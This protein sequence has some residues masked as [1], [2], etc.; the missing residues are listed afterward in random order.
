MRA[1]Y[2]GLCRNKFSIN[3]L[4][5]HYCNFPF[6]VS[7]GLTKLTQRITLLPSWKQYY[8]NVPDLS[9]LKQINKRLLYYLKI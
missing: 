8:C 2:K 1:I 6:S 5:V 9:Y 3:S 7:T 4:L